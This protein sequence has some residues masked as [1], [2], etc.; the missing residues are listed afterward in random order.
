M[1]EHS[2]TDKFWEALADISDENTQNQK[3]GPYHFAIYCSG[4]SPLKKPGRSIL[5]NNLF[6]RFPPHK[7]PQTTPPRIQ[8]LIMKKREVVVRH[9]ARL[10]VFI[11]KF[12]VFLNVENFLAQLSS[13]SAFLFQ[14]PINFDAGLKQ[15]QVEYSQNHFANSRITGKLMLCLYSIFA[16]VPS[17][18]PFTPKI[19][20][21]S[22]SKRS[23]HWLQ[24]DSG[25]FAVIQ[26][27]S[28]R[29][30]FSC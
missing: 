30:S 19:V 8:R 3:S 9:R 28:T 10:L 6:G 17:I 13:S 7:S 11:S 23:Q 2:I 4:N 24:T 16:C 14:L 15:A 22:I 26:F 12:L 5:R 21:V 25:Y 1:W 29:S 20:F 18:S 27:I